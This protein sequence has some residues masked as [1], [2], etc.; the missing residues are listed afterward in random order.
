MHEKSLQKEKGVGTLA[1]SQEQR[2]LLV[3]LMHGLSIDCQAQAL[4]PCRFTWEFLCSCFQ[5]VTFFLPERQRDGSLLGEPTHRRPVLPGP[6]LSAAPL[7][8]QPS[9]DSPVVCPGLKFDK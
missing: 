8:A 7:C 4:F 6:A 1:S 5:R 2:A 3:L 9:P